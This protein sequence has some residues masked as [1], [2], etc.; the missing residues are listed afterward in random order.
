[1]S[2]KHPTT[3]INFSVFK[4]FPGFGV[5]DPVPKP[6]I[7]E[8]QSFNQAFSNRV[9]STQFFVLLTCNF[10]F[11]HKFIYPEVGIPDSYKT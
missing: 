7:L 9:S 6:G 3:K 10:N 2:L 1:M 8:Y 5:K 11:L 4:F